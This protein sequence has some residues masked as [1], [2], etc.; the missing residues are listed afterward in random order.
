MHLSYGLLFLCLQS[1]PVQP[2]SSRNYYTP[3]CHHTTE[4]CEG[5]W[6]LGV[7]MGRRTK[8]LGHGPDPTKAEGCLAQRREGGEMAKVRRERNFVQFWQQSMSVTAHDLKH[9]LHNAWHSNSFPSAFSISAGLLMSWKKTPILLLR[10]SKS[11]Y[12]GITSAKS[13]T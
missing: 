2:S 13:V 1:S 6:R 5:I 11:I 12:N 7:H 4:R 10:S 3:L 8:R 9:L